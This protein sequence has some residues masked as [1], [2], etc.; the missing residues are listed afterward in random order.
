MLHAKYPE[1]A[2]FATLVHQWT[3][4]FEI[5]YPENRIVVNYDGMDDLVMLGAVQ[6]E[7]GYHDGP[8]MAAG[9]LGWTGPVAEVWNVPHFVDALSLPDRKGK[10]GYIIRSGRN[11]VKLKQ[12]DY[13]ELHRIVTNLSPRTVWQMLGD[14]KTVDQICD[15][16]PDEFYKY[17]DDIA[18]EL[19]AAASAITFETAIEFSQASAEAFEKRDENNQ[20]SRRAWAEA[21]KKKTNPGL[22]F[23]KLDGKDI[24]PMVWNMVKPRGDVKNLVEDNG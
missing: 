22:L 20:I 6:K 15:G 11:I 7:Y 5:I 12:A 21:I 14:G 18:G 23:A 19:Q 10:E 13:V 17:V 1:I 16:I 2:H 24:R 8:V 4:L 9:M 3:Y